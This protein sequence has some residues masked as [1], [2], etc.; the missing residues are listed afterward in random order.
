MYEEQGSN[1]YSTVLVI[2]SNTISI[3]E[4]KQ[5]FMEIKFSFFFNKNPIKSN[6]WG[7]FKEYSSE[8]RLL[9]H[10]N[11]PGLMHPCINLNEC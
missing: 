6:S 9:Y 3:R 10:I 4:I 7:Y 1:C 2:D 11:N 5:L 8:R